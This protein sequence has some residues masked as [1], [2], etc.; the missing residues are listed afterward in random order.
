MNRR[1]IIQILFPAVI[2]TVSLVITLVAQNPITQITNST[3][4]QIYPDIDGNRIVW[5]DH[6]SGLPHIYCYNILDSAE[7]QLS[8]VGSTKSEPRISGD[9]VI[10]ADNRNGK[11]DIYNYNFNYPGLGDYPLIDYPGDQNYADICGD[12][13]VYIDHSAGPYS[14]NLFMYDI[15]AGTFPEQITDDNMGPQ[16]SPSICK[17]LIV[18]QTYSG[19]SADIYLYNTYTQEFL[20]VCDD[21]NEQRNPT[22]YGRRIFWEDN[23]NGNWDIYMLYY[24]YYTGAMLHLEWP[25]SAILEQK[26][27]VKPN[28]AD[29]HIW[30]NNLVFA[31]DQSG[32]WDIY[33][34]SFHNKLWGTLIPISTAPDD[35]FGPRIFNDKIVW[36][37]DQDPSPSIIS[38][39]DIFLWERP[40]GADLA[41]SGSDEPDPVKTGN[42]ITYLFNVMNLGPLDA[43]GVV[44]TDTLSSFVNFVSANCNTGTCTQLGNYLTWTIGDLPSDSSAVLRITVQTTTDTVVEN[45]AGIAGNEIDRVSANNKVFLRTRVSDFIAATVDEGSSPSLALD[46]MG[47]VHVTYLTDSWGGD[48]MY[49]SNASGLWETQVL[50]NSGNVQSAAIVVDAAGNVHICYVENDWISAAKL[51]YTNNTGGTWQPAEILTENS[52][53]FWPLSMDIDPYDKLHISYCETGSMASSAPL[54]YLTNESGNWNLSGVG[55]SIYAYD[56]AAVAA[57]NTGN[58]HLSYYAINIGCS[59]ITDR[60]G[61]TWQAP[62]VVDVNWSGGQLEGMMTDI[63][64]DSLDRPH[65]SYVSG[66]GNPRQD[67]WYAVKTAGVWNTT[68]IDDGDFQSYGNR[69]DID[70]DNN[71]HILYYHS[72]SNQLRYATNAS[73][74]WVRKYVDG[75]QGFNMWDD[76]RVFDIASDPQGKVHLCYTKNGEVKYTTNAQYTSHYGGGEDGTGGYFFANS[77][78]GASGSPSQPTYN[79]IDPITAGHSEITNWTSGDGHD[80]FFGPQALN[81]NFGFFDST[82]NEVYIGSNGYL[83]FGDGYDLTATDASIPN[84]DEPNNLIAGCAMDLNLDYGTFADAHVYYGGDNSHF[85]VTYWHA[86]DEGSVPDYITLQI[87]LYPNGN[88][89]YQYNNLE[90][91]DPLP[92]SIG[93]DALVGIE[94]Y[95]GTQGISYR[96]NGS[97]GPLF[98]SPLAVMFGKNNLYLPIEELK[99]SAVP[100]DYALM[101]NFPNPFNPSTTIRYALPRIQKVEI[102]I[103]NILGQKIRSFQWDKQLPGVHQVI[104]DGNNS[105]GVS[106]G[107]GMYFYRITTGEFT[108]VR[109]MLLIR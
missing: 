74:S 45:R 20:T 81:F 3:D 36:F 2:V 63:V 97:G 69:I 109:K 80:G 32:N 34:Y 105:Q 59:Y 79:W 35:E 26:M 12:T 13:L 27:A 77:T 61:G 65:I 104:W 99:S 6:R 62:A 53:G 60:P 33:M 67:T 16:F 55:S 5:R 108:A 51:K 94:N 54:K 43:T 90:S 93:D 66:G 89:K 98:G 50:D 86:H 71:P 87:I 57:D 46:N 4:L 17:H 73:G 41:I 37:D 92:N 38:Q 78:N 72:Q 40:P 48:L 64:V 58:V 44:M 70:P 76:G 24:Y 96:N 21:P 49:A 75:E 68:F 101:Q 47:K 100:V 11:W 8:T 22:I 85:V 56:Y 30:G 1:R 19:P 107:T 23:R 15:A 18:F 91:T 42:T 31:D 52:S 84:I 95:N 25:L 9:R 82:Y 14:G 103:F 29:P 10:W 7:T 39:S 28:Q 88:I 106:A 102:T 83:T